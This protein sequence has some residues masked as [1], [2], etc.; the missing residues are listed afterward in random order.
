M[1]QQYEDYLNSLIADS[2]ILSLSD[3]NQCVHSIEPPPDLSTTDKS[4]T[5][6]LSW[7]LV[8]MGDLLV[9]ALLGD[10]RFVGCC[11][12]GW[13]VGWRVSQCSG[14]LRT[15]SSRGCLTACLMRWTNGW[16]IGW[17]CDGWVVWWLLQHLDSWQYCNLLHDMDLCALSH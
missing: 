10:G 14:W 11:T 7:L 6:L 16:L 12:V 2:V 8:W 9:A 13:M 3:L 5:C 1:E 15:R 4:V 17:F